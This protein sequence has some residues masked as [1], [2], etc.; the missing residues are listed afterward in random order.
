MR[1]ARDSR[2]LRLTLDRPEKR[3]ALSAALCRDLAR[4]LDAAAVEDSVGAVLLDSDGPVF[5][6]G[7]DLEE[8]TQPQAVDLTAIHESLFTAGSRINKPL[9]AAVQGAALGGG[10][11]LVANAHIVIASE[12]ATFALPE[13]RLGIWPMVIW[14]PVVSAIGERRAL[15]LS[16][17]ARTFDAREALALGLVHQVVAAAEV[18]GRAEAVARQVAGWSGLAVARGM[19]MAQRTRGMSDPEAVTLAIEMRRELLNSVEH[20]ELARAVREKRDGK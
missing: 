14:R 5:C 9:I 2:L 19:E 7:M 13:V 3:N 6:A 15:E 12:A 8:S 20:R 16:L 4:A 18:A 1:E 10:L 17:T 11:G